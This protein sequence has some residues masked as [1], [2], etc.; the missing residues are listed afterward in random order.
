MEYVIKGK[1]I[2]SDADTVLADINKASNRKYFNKIK[3]SNDDWVLTQ[4]PFHKDGQE[5]HPSFGVFKNR[6]GDRTFGSYHCFTCHETGDLVH[7][8]SH[9]LDMDL[10]EAT[11]WLID[12]YGN[13][14]IEK[15][16]NLPFI[17]LNRT[18]AI[19]PT[20]YMDESI[21]NNYNY[22]HPYMF[23]RK[24]T[25]EV[26]AKYKIG[27]DRETD[28]ITFPMWDEA[29]HLI[30]VNKRHTKF[31]KYDLQAS[32]FKAVYLLNFA[33]MEKATHVYVC[34]S[35]INALTLATY[36]LTAIALCGT[37][38]SKQYQI[39]RN[40]GIKNFTLCL[41]GDDAGRVGTTKFIKNVCDSTYLVDIIDIP[42]GKDVNDLSEDEFFSLDRLD[43][44][45]WNKKYLIGH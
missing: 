30:A 2:D 26:I 38:S 33:L 27:Y 43:K 22:L 1:V 45:A 23:K 16:L 15:Q 14:F 5:N 21:L 31:K 36:G 32:R 13:I 17:D 44:W 25:K 11:Q 35:Q 20:T 37:G 9:C 18:Q 12:K 24:L 4:C 39:L 3:P 28:S 19:K 40:C 29:N 41:D 8:V 10:E 7:L 34:E 42:E 6:E